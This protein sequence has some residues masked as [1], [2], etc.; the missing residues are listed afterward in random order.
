[1]HRDNDTFTFGSVRQSVS[2]PHNSRF[3]S[4][5]RRTRHFARIARRGEETKI[6]LYF[7]SSPLVSW[8]LT[9]ALL[10]KLVFLGE[11]RNTSSPK[12][13]YVGGYSFRAA[14]KMPRLPRLAHNSPVMQA[15]LYLKGLQLDFLKLIKSKSISQTNNQGF[16]KTGKIASCRDVSQA[17]TS[18]RWLCLFHPLLPILLEGE[19]HVK[20]PT[21]LFEERQG[22]RPRCMMGSI[23]QGATEEGTD[24]GPQYLAS[25]T[26]AVT[27]PKLATLS[28]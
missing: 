8:P 28:K 2:S 14:R 11:G 1:M 6:K 26:L 27:M 20:E 4:P 7:F 15:N 18:S 17:V 9:Q 10:V 25:C 5:A 12:N 24:T 13:A 22:R 21:L 23:S 16:K 19:V 3:M